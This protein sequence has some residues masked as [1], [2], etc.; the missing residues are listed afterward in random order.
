MASV[1][2][3]G[4]TY[5]DDSNPSTGMANGGHRARFIPALSDML[6]E[7]GHAADSAIEAAGYA[8][9]A[10]LSADRAGLSAA[11]QNYL[12]AWATLTGPAA[13]L[14]SVTHG[15]MLWALSVP[16]A[17]ITTAEPGVDP[18]WFLLGGL[19]PQETIVFNFFL[20]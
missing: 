19:D 12:G 16:L 8:V 13:A 17:D 6:V 4:N 14:V 18:V 1:T 3:N 9:D 11:A 5:T 2:L 7:A 10:D 15:G 20:G